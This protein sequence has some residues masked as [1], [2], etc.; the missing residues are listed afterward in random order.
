[1]GEQEDCTSAPLSAC[2][3]PR[4]DVRFIKNQLPVLIAI[5]L[6]LSDICEPAAREADETLVFATAIVTDMIILLQYKVFAVA[7]SHT[8]ASR[9]LLPSLLT[10]LELPRPKDSQCPCYYETYEMVLLS[11][12]GMSCSDMYSLC[13]G[14]AVQ[15]VL[16]QV[17]A[18]KREAKCPTCRAEFD[19]S[20][21]FVKEIDGVEEDEAGG[22]VAEDKVIQPWWMMVLRD[23]MRK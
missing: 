10:Q 21:H 1:M 23:G 2:R 16:S 18:G 11:A 5:C 7:H 19:M 22:F 9:S 13:R 8:L 15:T 20:K 17:R 6:R 12:W 14:C 3:I 4:S